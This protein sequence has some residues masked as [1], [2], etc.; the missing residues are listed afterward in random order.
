MACE[1]RVRGK[2]EYRGAIDYDDLVRGWNPNDPIPS[3]TVINTSDFGRGVFTRYSM[4]SGWQYNEAGWYTYPEL[5]LRG[6]CVPPSIDPNQPCDCVN[7]GCVPK[8]TYNTPG[9]FPSLA[10]CQ[11]G[12]AKNSSC[13]GECISVD[14]IAALQQAAAAVRGRICK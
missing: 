2:V 4:S 3:L 12:C 5:Y 9:V 8:T 14:E 1:L 13:T 7:G 6:D 10:A 11:S